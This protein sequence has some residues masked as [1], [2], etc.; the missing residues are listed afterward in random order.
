[1]KV[2]ESWHLARLGQSGKVPTSLMRGQLSGGSNHALM[3]L[4]CPITLKPKPIR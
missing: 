2:L 3:M 1:M 4:T